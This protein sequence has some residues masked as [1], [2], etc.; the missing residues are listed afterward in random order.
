MASTL[1]PELVEEILLRVPP[2]EPAHLIRAALVCKPWC[3]IL[4]DRRFLRRYRSFHRS[5]PLLGYIHNLYYPLRKGQQSSRFVPTTIPSPVS[6]PAIGCRWWAFDCRHGRVLVKVFGDDPCRLVVWNPITGEQHDVSEPPCSRSTT[7]THAVLCAMEG[8]DHLDCHGGPFLV[9]LVETSNGG[10]D[11][12]MVSVYL[13]DTGVWSARTYNIDVDFRFKYFDQPSV[14]AGD[15]L[16]FTFGECWMSGILKYDLC[17][18]ELSVIDMPA[19]DEDFTAK[20]LIKLEEGGIGLVSM[21]DN[22]IYMWSRTDSIGGWVEHR[23]ME[24]DMLLH[25]HDQSYASSV[26]GIV[27]GTNTIFISTY[28]IFTLDLKS[29][30]AR[31]VGENRDPYCPMLPYMSFY[32]PK[33]ASCLSLL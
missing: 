24:L 6:T 11:P 20:S 12:L 13:S 33:L 2:D 25:K 5:P 28:A 9:V 15:A 22:C 8:C 21:L 27:E 16:Y 14:L 3:H 17:K 4:S 18:Y 32:T 29:R 30:Q 31:K 7:T 1:L 23:V 10:E 26:I 19:G